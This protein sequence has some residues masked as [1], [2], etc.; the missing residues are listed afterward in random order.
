MK[1]NDRKKSEDY[2]NDYETCEESS[3]DTAEMVSPREKE[4]D[5]RKMDYDKVFDK[6]DVSSVAAV[7]IVSPGM[8]EDKKCKMPAHG[9]SLS[10]KNESK[11]LKIQKSNEIAQ[12]ATFLTIYETEVEKDDNKDNQMVEVN[13]DES[14]KGKQNDAV[15]D[16][17]N[18][19]IDSSDYDDDDRSIY[20]SIRSMKEMNNC[21][22][23]DDESVYFTVP[24]TTAN[25]DPT[26]T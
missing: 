10:P 1:A 6:L 22:N 20:F 26:I 8:E 9:H 7:G 18:T 16:N 17:D 12:Q 19:M 2:K 4:K 13:E 24:S 11:S 5:K 21:Q 14:E 3:V 25:N 23:S 15:I